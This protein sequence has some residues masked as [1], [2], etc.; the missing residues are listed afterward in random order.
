M[1]INYKTLT[2]SAIALL[3]VDSFYLGSFGK[4]LFDKMVKSIQGSSIQLNLLGAILS[5][6]CLIVLLNYFVLQKNGYLLD[7]FILGFCVY[8]V[9]DATN[10]AIFKNYDFSIGLID[11]IWG[12]VLFTLVTYINRLF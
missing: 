8:G 12:G 3:I 7:A 10:L 6:V 2:I 11:S 9:F 1:K 4:S 5:Y